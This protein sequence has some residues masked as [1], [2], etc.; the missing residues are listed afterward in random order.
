VTLSSVCY[1]QFNMSNSF[2]IAWE[3]S[4][5]THYNRILNRPVKVIYR[6]IYISPFIQAGL[7]AWHHPLTQLL[8]VSVVL[9]TIP[10]LVRHHRTTPSL[11]RHHR[12]TPTLVRPDDTICRIIETL[13][14][15]R[16]PT[17][18]MQSPSTGCSA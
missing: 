12:T 5:C 8:F 11:V 10:S 1:I 7:D 16:L 17:L 2:S 14:L 15:T 13:K 6:Q 4:R 18:T 9:R 3:R